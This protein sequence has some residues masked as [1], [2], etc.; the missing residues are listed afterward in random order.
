MTEADAAILA[1]SLGG[2]VA[3]SVTMY[4]CLKPQTRK[5]AKPAGAHTGDNAV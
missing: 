5:S 1:L 3:F 2:L 4:H